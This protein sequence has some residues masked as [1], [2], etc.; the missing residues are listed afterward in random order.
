MSQT[1]LL[2]PLRRKDGPNNG[3]P[4]AEPLSDPP[5]DYKASVLCG[6][7]PATIMECAYRAL[8]FWTHQ[9]AQEQMYQQRNYRSLTQKYHQLNAEAERN[10]HEA[11]ARIQALESQN[12]AIE[13]D[14]QSMDEKYAHLLEQYRKKS[15]KQAQ[16][17]KLYDTLKR[18][19]MPGQVEQLADN[20]VRQTLHSLPQTER[21]Q[22]IVEPEQTFRPPEPLQRAQRSI[23]RYARV[24]DGL[25]QLHPHQRSGSS[26]CGSEQRGML[27]PEGL[28]ISWTPKL[29]ATSGTPLQRT[30]F[31]AQP[32]LGI[33]QSPI[34]GTVSR[35]Q[36][37]DRLH[38]PGSSRRQRNHSS[39]V[40]NSAQSQR[41]VRSGMK[42]GRA[43][44]S[45]SIDFGTRFNP[46]EANIHPPRR[47]SDQAGSAAPYSA[48]Y[49]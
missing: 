37:P 48:G 41:A 1:H 46:Y 43:G 26:V 6:L 35:S 31:P 47:S 34:T 20:D 16:T 22:S 45:G 36:L 29:V 30:A 14:R 2:R 21:M 10:V 5:E 11:N 4:G 7:D 40:M 9:N 42:F 3:T 15:Q 28:R 32:R 44:T 38:V 19:V 13:A 12:K 27:P 39:K 24:Q 17:Q 49:A 8:S 23:P 25:E 33:N 18:K